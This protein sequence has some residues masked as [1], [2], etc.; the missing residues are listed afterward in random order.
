MTSLVRRFDSFVVEGKNLQRT[1]QGGIKAPGRFTRVGI[2][3]Y[4]LEDG[5]TRREWRPPEEVFR[6]ESYSTLEDAPITIHHPEDGEV[7]ADSYSNETVGHVRAGVKP[8]GDAFLGGLVVIQDEH[9]VKQA[10]SGGLVE[11][12]A[13]YVA[14]LDM[15]AGVVP[16]GQPD[17]GKPYDCIQRDIKYNHVALLPPGLGRAGPEVALRLDSKGNQLPIRK[18][19]HMELTPE[20]LAALKSLAAIAP[21]I[22]ELVAPKQPETPVVVATTDT[23]DKPDEEILAAPPAPQD[24]EKKADEDDEEKKREDQ[25]R[26]VN[27][28]IEIRDQARKVL[29]AEYAFRGKSNR[30]VMLDVLKRVDSKID[31]SKRSDDAVRAAFEVSL[32]RFAEQ[33]AAQ[34][35]QHLAIRAQRVDSIDAPELKHE[36]SVSDA[37]KSKSA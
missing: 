15:T 3:E 20:E 18:D 17:A 19:S 10:L 37:W 8:E 27:D 36:R 2:L 11:F 5:S 14:R 22:Q 32:A 1:P 4:D 12:S 30:T 23:E 25:E 29:G 34:S 33:Q 6:P 24:P 13:G 7:R 21:K 9:A 31:M 28:S 26:L 16:D 35:S